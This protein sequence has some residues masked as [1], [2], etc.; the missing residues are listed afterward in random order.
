[1]LLLF[2]NMMFI[3][4]RAIYY[5]YIIFGLVPIYAGF[6]GVVYVFIHNFGAFA[7]LFGL[8]LCFGAI[9]YGALMR[10]IHVQ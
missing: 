4:E 3:E 7:F 1:M 2:S 10:R 6:C 8:Y 9:T 5:P